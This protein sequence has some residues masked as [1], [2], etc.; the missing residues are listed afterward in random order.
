MEPGS[1][2]AAYFAVVEHDL[3]KLV[4]RDQLP[5]ALWPAGGDR[6]YAVLDTLLQDPDNPWW[7]RRVDAARR[8]EA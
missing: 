4:F 5:S 3:E 7:G 2:A 8:G 1:A 6:W